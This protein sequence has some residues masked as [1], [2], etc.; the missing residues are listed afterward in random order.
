[1]PKTAEAG[2]SS[3]GQIGYLVDTR[4]ERTSSSNDSDITRATARQGRLHR[5]TRPSTRRRSSE[6]E[7]AVEKV[8]KAN[9]KPE[10]RP[11]MDKYVQFGGASVEPK[12]GEIVAIYGGEDA[13]RALHQQRR[14]HRC[15]GRLDL[16][17][18]RAG[19][20]DARRRARP[21]ARSEQGRPSAPVS[22]DRA[23]TTATNKLKIK[24][25]D[26][27]IWTDEDGKE[28]CQAND[29][30][31][32]LRAT[33]P[34]ARRWSSPST[35]RSCSSAWTSASTRCGRR[36]WTRASSRTASTSTQPVVLARHLHAQRDPHGRRL[37]DLRRQRQAARAVLGRRRSSTRAGASTST[38]TKPK[39]AFD[40]RRRRTT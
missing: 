32:A 27:T 33:S 20:G 2:D 40:A 39:Q 10:K 23:S 9:I 14:Q 34:C 4:Q 26:G 7:N 22:P 3:S 8:R 36:P 16:Q 31:R 13:T 35:R 15:P 21:Q 28:C 38:R 1:M 25:Y 17:A 5:S 37:R 24:N 18:V 11:K 6:L 30:Q 12:T 29:E 19:R